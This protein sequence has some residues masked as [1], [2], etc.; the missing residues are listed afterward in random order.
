MP[1][2]AKVQWRAQQFLSAYT[3]RVTARTAQIAATEITQQI[4]A[5]VGTPY[6]PASRPGQPPH[7][8]TGRLQRSVGGNTILSG[9]RLIVT[10]FA[11]AFHAPF[12]QLGTRHIRP[13][14]FLFYTQAQLARLMQGLRIAA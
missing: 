4:K 5:R 9:N 2:T 6:P 14:P 11:T 8:R 3:R 13:R 1:A 12:M 10:H 7:R